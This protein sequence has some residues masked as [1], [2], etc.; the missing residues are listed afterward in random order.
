MGVDKLRTYLE[1]P[2]DVALRALI[3]ADKA[4]ATEIQQLQ[5]LE[6]LILY[7]QWLFEFVNN[8]VSLPRLFNV[9]QRAMFEMGTL[10]LWGRE[11]TFSVKVENRRVHSELAKN[12]GM[13]LFYLQITGAEPE[14]TY[15][16]AVPVTRGDAKSF[17]VGQRGVFFTVTGRELDAQIVQIVLNPISFWELMKEP[18]RRFAGLITARLDQLTTTIQKEAETSIGKASSSVETSIQTGIR[19]APQTAAQRAAQ[20]PT[21]TP[22]P[23]PVATPEPTRAEGTRPSGTVRDLM[24]GTGFL[25]AGLGTALKLLSDMAEKLRDKTTL[26][27]LLKIIGVFLGV[28]C[29]ITA[30]NAWRKVRRRDV[31]VLLQASGW[32][33]NRRMRLTAPMARLFARNI[34]LPKDARKRRKDLLV[35]LERLARQLQS[36]R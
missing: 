20:P 9:G 4:A 31:G 11:F 21:A 5:N 6:K 19:Q 17:Y 13:Y 3:A 28:I 1:G 25:V 23:V 30:I 10:I 2:H 22:V 34:G 12:S 36:M 29:L 26:F 8:Y 16:I 35:P 27:M 32:A 18:F 33:I 24:I 15:E 14:D 7:H